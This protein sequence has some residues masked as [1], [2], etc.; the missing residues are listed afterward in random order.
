MAAETG[1]RV[2]GV[3][4][5]IVDDLD[6][7]D[8]LGRIKLHF[9]VLGDDVTSNWARIAAPMAGNERGVF[10]Q[11]EVDDEALVVFEQGD[12]RAP[13]VIGFLWNG[14]DA[15]PRDK[16]ALRT[17][18]TVSG[19]TI[20]FD[21][22]D[23]KITVTDANDHTVVMDSD[24]IALTVGDQKVEMTSSSIK[25]TAGSSTLEL[26]SSSIALKSTQIQLN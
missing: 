6:D 8:G 21:D 19:N 16:P 24:G 15:P 11:P 5:G 1:Q 26:S 22:D 20:E 23:E 25:L 9:P 13:Y 7:P 3:V 12:V 14:S 17:I 2:Y 4:V 10:F 18:K